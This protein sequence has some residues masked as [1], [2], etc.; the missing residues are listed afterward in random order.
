MTYPNFFGDDDNA[1]NI[2]RLKIRLAR[3][4]STLKGM[5]QTNYGCGHELAK[6][7]SGEYRQA[8]QAVNET[9]DELALIDPNTPKTRF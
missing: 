9:L 7:L 3:Q 8:C 2:A 4:Y 1:E 5:P 6:Y